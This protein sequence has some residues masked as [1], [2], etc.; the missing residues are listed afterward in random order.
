VAGVRGVR[1]TLAALKSVQP[2]INIAN[3][4]AVQ[5]AAQN[6]ASTL[7]GT[8]PSAPLSNMAG[9]GP[10]RTDVRSGR[11]EGNNRERLVS[12][13]LVGPRWTVASDMARKG[14][15]TMVPNLNAKYGGASRWAWPVVER[16]MPTIQGRIIAS[17]EAVEKAVTVKM[18]Y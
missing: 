5:G 3:R 17:V 7:Q 6:A 2:L 9:D 10:T 13:V 1:E 8:A 14:E 4:A 12:V 18:R 15:G 16:A 11:S